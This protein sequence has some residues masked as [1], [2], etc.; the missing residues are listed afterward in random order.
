MG[1]LCL[2]DRPLEKGGGKTGSKIVAKV[3]FPLNGID[4]SILCNPFMVIGVA[5]ITH[6]THVTHMRKRVLRICVRKLFI[7]KWH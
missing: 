5:L 1:L 7:I 4:W 6:I 2:L 3:L